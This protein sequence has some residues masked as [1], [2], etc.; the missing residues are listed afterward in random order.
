MNAVFAVLHDANADA[1][2]ITG[3][4]AKRSDKFVEE[5]TKEAAAGAFTSL[6]GRK[7]AALTRQVPNDGQKASKAEDYG[8]FLDFLAELSVCS[9]SR[10]AH[11]I[12]HGS[13]KEKW[14]LKF[15][16]FVLFTSSDFTRN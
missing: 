8:P 11:H 3:R 15:H 4:A 13:C 5:V 16:R 12:R 7:A 1:Q 10:P 14:L 9:I 6:T 2:L